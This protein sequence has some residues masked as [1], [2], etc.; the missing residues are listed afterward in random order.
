[1]STTTG[2]SSCAD[3]ADQQRLSW[4]LCKRSIRDKLLGLIGD[5]LAD[6]QGSTIV[7]TLLLM[8]LEQL[9]ELLLILM[10]FWL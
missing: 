7:Q 4:Q 6:T 3:W 10:T 2:E 8:N 1:M 5:K 9:L